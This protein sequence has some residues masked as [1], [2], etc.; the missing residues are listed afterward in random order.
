MILV[1]DVGTTGLRAS[2]VR[3]DATLAGVEYRPFAPELTVP[4]PRR[5]RRGPPCRARAR[6]RRHRCC[7]AP[8]TPPWPASASPTSGRARS[9]GNAP[10]ACPI[11]PAL[12]WQDLRTVGECITA[13]AE[14]GI[15]LAPNQSAT[16]I[17][18]LL[19]NAAAGRD[20]AELCFG[21]VDTWVAW[22]LSQGELHVTDHSN[23]A[24]TGLYAIEHGAWH[25]GVCERSACPRCCCPRS[26][27]PPASSAWRRRCRAAPPIA[28]LVGDQQ[29]SL[30]G[31]GCTTPGHGEDHVRH[32]RHA[33]RVPRRHRPG[34]RHAQRQRHVPDRRLEHRAASARGAPRRSC[35]RRA[36]TWNGSATTW[37]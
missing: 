22:T 6:R 15:R 12:G 13:K 26:S 33:R 16:K 14:H 17:G 18:W 1:I 30:A 35:C 20:P 25:P 37:G 23:A 7:T 11:A 31:Q 9:C 5:V 27:T 3:P 19:A 10:P 2:L 29:A 28:A 8:A 34:R 21:T 4:G 24:V 36:P 32:R